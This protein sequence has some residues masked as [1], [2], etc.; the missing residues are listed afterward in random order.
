MI[1]GLSDSSALL[2]QAFTS[3][4]GAAPGTASTGD[5]F[6]LYQVLDVKPA[7][8][9]DFAEYKSHVLDDYREQRMPQLLEQATSKL[10]ERAKVLGDLKKAAAEQK[11][12]VKTSDLVGQDG[13]V[14]DLGSMS[15]PGKVAFSL[16][17]GAISGP[18]NAGVN[19]VV[20][21]VTD[22]QQPTQDEIAKNLD[23][24]RE[25]LLNT[26]KEQ[27]FE[28]FLGTLTKKYQDG[29][30]IKLSKQAEAPTGIPSGL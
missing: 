7:H 16:A 25:Q 22:K 3:T 4:K 30:G 6:A 15:G 13:Q 8:A 29:G 11:I 17:K 20:L 28:V 10:A 27:I 12:A 5:G 24:T 23:T 18:I 2:G 26:Q 21:A 1:G 14:T 9:P 19:G